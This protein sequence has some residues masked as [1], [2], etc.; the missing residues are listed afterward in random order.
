MSKIILSLIV[1]FFLSFDVS[2]NND[3]ENVIGVND[4]S[5]IMY[6]DS[7]N[8]ENYIRVVSYP[9]GWIVSE[10]YIMDGSIISCEFD[11]EANDWIFTNHDGNLLSIPY[12][13]PKAK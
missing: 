8:N 5:K 12:V 4:E 6:C 3:F 11:K 9:R 7:N 13:A 1:L 10:P 2:A